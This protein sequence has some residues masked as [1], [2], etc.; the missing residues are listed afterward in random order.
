MD[1]VEW[2]GTFG[3]SWSVE[4]WVSNLRLT[5]GPVD[6][7]GGCRD[8]RM[9]TDGES[10]SDHLH[11]VSAGYDIDAE[12]IKECAASLAQ[13]PAAARYPYVGGWLHGAF[14]VIASD[15]RTECSLAVCRTCQGI[16]RVLA[17]MLAWEQ[18]EVGEAFEQITKNITSPAPSVSSTPS[19]WFRRWRRR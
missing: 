10:S 12:E 11:R 16:S 8:D 15:H 4:G 6:N 19:G 13:Q 1:E 14:M 5:V 3:S 9:M 7:K 18:T 2:R 17:M